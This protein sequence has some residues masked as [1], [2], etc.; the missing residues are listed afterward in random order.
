MRDIAEAKGIDLGDGDRKK[1]R[2][3]EHDAVHKG[4][5]IVRAKKSLNLRTMEGKGDFLLASN[6]RL[7]QFEKAGMIQETLWVGE[8]ESAV[9]I[10]APGRYAQEKEE[11]WKSFTN[12]G[13]KVDVRSLSHS[14]DE[15]ITELFNG[16]EI[17]KE[18]GT[19]FSESAGEY[20]VGLG[21]PGVTSL[22]HYEMALLVKKYLDD[23]S[24]H[25]LKKKLATPYRHTQVWQAIACKELVSKQIKYSIESFVREGKSVLFHDVESGEDVEVPNWN[26]NL[27]HTSR[28]PLTGFPDPIQQEKLSERFFMQSFGNYGTNLCGVKEYAEDGKIKGEIVDE[29]KVQ[30]AMMAYGWSG[31]R[32]KL[33]D[34]TSLPAL[35]ELQ[36][37][38]AHAIRKIIGDPISKPVLMADR[39]REAA[40]RMPLPEHDI[41]F[42]LLPDMG[43]KIVPTSGVDAP[44]NFQVGSSEPPEWLSDRKGFFANYFIVFET[45]CVLKARYALT[46]D[47]DTYEVPWISITLLK[48]SKENP[49]TGTFL[50]DYALTTTETQNN[51]IKEGYEEW[52]WDIEA[53]KYIIRSPMFAVGAKYPQLLE[54]ESRGQSSDN[55]DGE[56]VDMAVKILNF[57]LSKAS[58]TREE[59][60]D[61]TERKRLGRQAG[62]HSKD[63]VNP[64]KVVNLRKI[65]RNGKQVSDDIAYGDGADS[66]K[67]DKNPMRQHWVTGHYRQQP[68][69]IGRTLTKL[70]YIEPFIKGTE[71]GVPDQRTTVYRVA[72]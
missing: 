70:I 30:R 19:I 29:D 39:T 52:F 40:L 61:R 49:T 36:I 41:T 17:W 1:R 15:R 54:D 47:A 46:T 5:K 11:K 62:K 64:I 22:S 2:R 58:V 28:L 48:D 25:Y 12:A 45:P 27:L 9:R 60:I 63:I 8:E 51:L 53:T 37:K 69:G 16:S 38:I 13:E 33:D 72:R 65:E 10:A 71:G 26:W 24:N 57:M 56:V 55:P 21:K 14:H 6:K 23:K 18:I 31:M 3:E 4:N 42:D 50:I 32:A 67:K 20:L 44:E 34:G 66:S 43:T 68:H 59:N 7:E 35:Q